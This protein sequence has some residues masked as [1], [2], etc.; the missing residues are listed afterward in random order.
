MKKTASE[1][2]GLQFSVFGT[3]N[4]G[5]ISSNSCPRG[6]RLQSK[7]HQQRCGT[8]FRLFKLLTSPMCGLEVLLQGQVAQAQFITAYGT[9]D[10]CHMVV[11][12][13][14]WCEQKSR[15]YF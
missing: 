10:S 11:A 14:D 2:E 7:G 3:D 4:T 15:S 13:T 9:S 12:P 8:T 5:I 6:G 1:T